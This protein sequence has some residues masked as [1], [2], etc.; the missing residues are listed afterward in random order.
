[1]L[2]LTVHCRAVTALDASL[3]ITPCAIVTLADCVKCNRALWVAPY[4]SVESQG[5]RHTA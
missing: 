2:G 4:C 5:A 3:L 1:M